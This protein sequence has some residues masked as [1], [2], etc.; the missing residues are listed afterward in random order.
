MLF[1]STGGIRPDN[2]AAYLRDPRILA[3]G[4]SWLCKRALINAGQFAEIENLAAQAAQIV[5]EVR[6]KEIL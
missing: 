2:L 6:S 3:V 5:K 1:R 4:G